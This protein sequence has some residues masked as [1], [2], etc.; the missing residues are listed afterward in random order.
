MIQKISLLVGLFFLHFTA[1]AVDRVVQEFGGVGTFG[2]ITAA[3]N[4]ASDGDRIVIVNRA[5]GLNWQENVSINKS[6]SFV[7]AVDGTR[8][9]VQGDFIVAPTTTPKEIRII[10]MEIVAGAVFSSNAAPIGTRTKVEIAGCNIAGLVSFNHDNYD[11][12]LASNVIGGDVTIRYGNVYGNDLGEH[13]LNINNDGTPS[14]EVIYIVGNYVDIL[15]WNSSA[16]FFYIANNFISYN[17]T[18]YDDGIGINTL[19]N[20]SLVTNVILNNSIRIVPNTCCSGTP[21]GIDVG[22]SASQARVDILNNA[23]DRITA[24]SNAYGIRVSTSA[25]VFAAYNH[26]D[27]SITSS[28]RLTGITPNGTNV[29]SFTVDVSA[30]DGTVTGTAVTNG[31]SPDN[32]YT[33]H[34][35]SINDPG[36]FGGSFNINNYFPISASPSVYIVRAPRAIFQGGTL[37]IEAEGYDR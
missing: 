13:F 4:A 21:I 35:L 31:G 28:R 25:N 8:F 3:V 6:L 7:P 2:S 30:S 26:I 15:N 18:G 34:D 20:S 19:K 9:R 27:A 22:G 11:V 29:T 36:C 10:G 32:A 14:N 17:N 5:G 23:I 33:D 12:T 37:N 1:S 16:H 24:I